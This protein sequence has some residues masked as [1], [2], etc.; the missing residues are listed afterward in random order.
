VF[1]NPS[2]VR[3]CMLE[4]HLEQVKNRRRTGVWIE[5]D[6]EQCPT[7]GKESLIEVL[8]RASDL[9]AFWLKISGSIL[10]ACSV[11]H[12]NTA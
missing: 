12:G 6:A 1:I 4:E 9:S 2:P 11:E 8:D 5:L 3:R 7:G 10:G